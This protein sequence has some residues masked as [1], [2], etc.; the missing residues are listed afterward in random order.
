M[1]KA[2]KVN[3]FATLFSIIFIV[4]GVFLIIHL[5]NL[6][7]HNNAIIAEDSFK[8]NTTVSNILTS[9]ESES[10][11]DISSQTEL[12]KVEEKDFNTILN[13]YQPSDTVLEQQV[14]KIIE[15]EYQNN[16]L[17]AQKDILAAIN[18]TNLTLD[19]LGALFLP[20]H[21]AQ[22][23]NLQEIQQ[24]D[25]P[26]LLQ[27]DPEWRDLRYGSNTSQQ[28][29]ENGCAIVS[30][31]MVHANN[32]G[33]EVLPQ[34]ILDWSK[35]TYYVHNAGTSW[36]IFYDFAQHFGYSMTNFGS[37]FYTAMEAVQEGQIIVASVEP[38]F[39]TETGHILVIRGYEDGKVYVNDPND[40][41]SKMYSIQGI[42]ERIFLEDG[43]NYWA[44]Y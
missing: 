40:D 31:A 13:K 5:G 44:F 37:D 20:E 6:T 33:K 30:L 26:L 43:L 14:Q 4:V 39:F 7:A 22:E 18:D 29:G 12:V 2:T 15:T 38:G 41:P 25:V 27:K 19:E 23:E 28:L 36:T 42:D 11:V 24:I 32:S 16:P 8:N 34:D 3:Y 1:P 9:P 21:P 17:T 10:S 35:E